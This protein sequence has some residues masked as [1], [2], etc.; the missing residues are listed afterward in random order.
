MIGFFANIFGYLLDFLYKFLSNYGLAIILFS[1]IIK[2]LMLPLSI[3]QQKSVKKN[4]KIQ[5][6]MKQ[7]QFKYKNNPEK[8]NQETIELYKREKMNPF[9]GCF[10]AIIQIVL[11]FSVFYLVRSPLTY[12]KKVN[13]DIINKYKTQIQEEKLSNNSGYPEIEIIREIDNLK[14]LEKNKDNQEEIDSLKLN[15]EFLGLDLSKVPTKSLND[16]K[17]YIIPVLYVISSFISMRISTNMQ[18]NSKNKEDADENSEF[19]S[20]E[21]ANKSMSWIMPI[22]S[23][24]IAIVAPL[25]LALYWLVNNVLMIAERLVLNRFV[26]DE[27]ENENV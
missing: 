17:V 12:M 24:S 22:M 16:Y 27:E 19:N 18:T 7:I 6:E 20:L 23:V 11:L 15:M 14:S 3:K 9:S 10:S 21:Q 8:L 13:P 2:L 5:D 4:A 26:K 1:I 25:G